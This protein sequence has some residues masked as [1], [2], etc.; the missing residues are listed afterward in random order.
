MC[1]CV[2]IYIKIIGENLKLEVKDKSNQLDQSISNED[3]LTHTLEDKCH[4]YDNEIRQLEKLNDS[5]KNEI[6]QQR[7][8]YSLWYLRNKLLAVIVDKMMQLNT[9][10]T[11]YIFS[12][13]YWLTFHDIYLLIFIRIYTFEEDI[14]RRQTQINELRS[15]KGITK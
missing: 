7:E 13:S 3:K 2:Y 12:L 1:L 15:E 11:H 10:Y 14:H 6:E 8:R 9:M 4:R 5:H